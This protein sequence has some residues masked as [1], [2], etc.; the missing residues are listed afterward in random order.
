MSF[1]EYVQSLD[2]LVMTGEPEEARIAAARAAGIRAGRV[3]HD[4]NGE[5]LYDRLRAAYGE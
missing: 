3:P 5:Y 2:H 4:A 1:E